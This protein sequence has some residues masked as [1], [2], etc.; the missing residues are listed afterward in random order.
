M[1]NGGQAVMP[2]RETIVRTRRSTRVVISLAVKIRVLDSVVGNQF[3]AGRS[4]VVNQYGCKIE[5]KTSFRVNQAAEITVLA[6]GKT[7][8]G[9]VVWAD[10][11]VNKQGNYE[12]A[13]QFDGPSNIWGVNFP[14]EDGPV[15]PKAQE[16]TPASTPR[17]A[18]TSES[19]DQTVPIFREDQE[20]TP[21]SALSKP[22]KSD[23]VEDF[24]FEILEAE[25]TGAP[26][27]SP[28]LA[29]T[30]KTEIVTAPQPNT[31]VPPFLPTKTVSSPPEIEVPPAIPVTPAE[32]LLSAVRELV[33]SSL[34]AEQAVAAERQARDLE[35]RMA[36]IQLEISNRV[37]EQI[38]SVT[39]AQISLLK[40]RADE[41]ASQSQRVLFTSLQQFAETAD[42]KAKAVQDET[43]S[44]M[45]TALAGLHGQM[46]EQ[47]SQT[48]QIYVA[49]C[50]S[51]AEQALSSMVDDSLRTLSLRIEELNK[52]FGEM[53]DRTQN[54]LLSTTRELE[55]HA[56][57]KV[58]ATAKHLEE[59]LRGVGQ[60]IF[61][62]FEKCSVAE[63]GK[64]QESIAAAFRQEM[65]AVS[66]S[67]LQ[68]LQGALARSL[69]DMADKMRPVASPGVSVSNE[70]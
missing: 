28:A 51:L 10:A 25:P 70:P 32:R 34:S 23:P 27:P 58:D 42:Q 63:L 52:G 11:R 59:R 3:V 47:L 13:L 50:R 39:A 17:P 53:Q 57:T 37:A 43:V 16:L 67:N 40:Q 30:F 55:E 14:P 21:A 20:V 26:V 49:R 36:R 7:G 8:K 65:D 18:I 60:Q 24:S 38:Q 69:H 5:S 12:F 2:E 62:E 61:T 66:R 22:A 33:Q 44:A 1:Q 68:E 31:E 19:P 56:A 6:T 41:F 46:A 29:P 4:V 9:K 48:E 15:E 64:K 35:E 45:A 54:I